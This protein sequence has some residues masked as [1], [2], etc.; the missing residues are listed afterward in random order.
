MHII[1]S[2]VSS[3]SSPPPPPPTITEVIGAVIS[4][5]I[6]WLLTGVLVY[7]A[8]QRIIN[9]DYEID[10]DVMLITAVGGVFVNVL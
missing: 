2:S 10:A 3:C 6:I 4:V 1:N 9:Q 7:E 8:I 5:L